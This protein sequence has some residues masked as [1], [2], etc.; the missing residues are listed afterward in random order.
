MLG[1]Q[2]FSCPN[3]QQCSV[4][5]VVCCRQVVTKVGPKWYLQI[6]SILALIYV[7]KLHPC[8]TDFLK[9]F[10]KPRIPGP[11]L[12]I[13]DARPVLQLSVIITLFSQNMTILFTSRRDSQ[14]YGQDVGDLKNS[15]WAAHHAPTTC[16]IGLTRY[17]FYKL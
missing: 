13:G 9:T 8:K 5:V 16:L 2:S 14:Y 11:R 3:Q 12:G 1:I 15:H 6:E 7:T 17:N 4:E 10:L